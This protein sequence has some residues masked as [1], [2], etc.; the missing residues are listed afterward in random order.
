MSN[1]DRSSLA[2]LVADL[3]SGRIN[4]RSFLA[5]A[6]TLGISTALAGTLLESTTGTASATSTGRGAVRFVSFQD[7]GKTLV[8]GITQTT[9]QLDPSIAGS[10]G[11][12]DII[13][14]NENLYEGLTRYVNGS[15]EI[16]PIS[17]K[18]K[19][20]WPSIGDAYPLLSHP[21]ASPMGFLIGSPP[22]SV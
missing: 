14:I 17:A 9:V 10:N 12:G 8:I 19:P 2:I 4:R 15:A 22:I 18:P 20:R 11:Y 6:G 1:P 5:A 3:A 21:A 13:P 7:G 16:E